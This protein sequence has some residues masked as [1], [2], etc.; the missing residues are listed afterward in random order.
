MEVK[1]KFLG[2]NDSE[3]E[4]DFREHIR[5]DN[6]WFPTFLYSL[7]SEWINKGYNISDI[8]I[9]ENKP[10]MV[11]PIKNYIPFMSSQHKMNFTPT[12]T[13]IQTV[14]RKFVEADKLSQGDMFEFSF[15]VEGLGVFRVSYSSDE[16]GVGMSIRYLTFNLPVMS[17]MKYPEFYKKFIEGLVIKS[18]VKIPFKDDKKIIETAG[19]KSGGLILH[20]GATGSGKS[21]S[22]S[23]EVG[24]I[25]D[26]ITG[27]IVTYEN[28]IEYRYTA[29]KAPVR[30]FEIG[31]D[32]TEDEDH[33]VFENIKRHILRNNPSVVVYGE[34]RTN[35]EIREVMDAA[36]RGHLVFATIHAS[37][38]M[39][40]LTTLMGIVQDEPRLLENILHAIVAHKLVSNKNGDFIPL[41]EILLPDSVI[42]NMIGKQE[43][44]QIA[45]LFIKGDSGK[46][47]G[48]TFTKALNEAIK[49]DLLTP[50]EAE[51][52][53]NSN[54]ETQERKVEK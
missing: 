53:R 15:V 33:T 23:S 38:V 47:I 37:S 29:V 44:K 30:Q 42:K 24:Y 32:I 17:N 18:S 9:R 45:T 26:N 46:D 48:I 16:Q 43:L 19:V 49:A 7:K 28:P 31:K 34:A 39:E 12:K 51:R 11:A 5:E 10:I 36:A 54:Y 3:I 27:T 1:T 6:K 20:V 2:N 14:V 40:A 25:A 35:Q 52:I 21:T 22:I 8:L 4:L 41:Y 13:Q 50:T